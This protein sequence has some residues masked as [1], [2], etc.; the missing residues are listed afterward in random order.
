[1]HLPKPHRLLCLTATAALA[2]AALCGCSQSDD[3]SPAGRPAGDGHI[4]FGAYVSTASATRANIANIGSLRKTGFGVFAATTGDADYDASA[5]A[6]FTCDFMHNQRVFWKADAS[7]APGVGTWSYEPAKSWPA[8]KVT[9]MA[10]APYT[11][12]F[13]ET[14]V[15]AVTAADSKGSPR[16]SFRMASKVSEQTDLIYSDTQ[17]TSNLRNGGQ[18]EFNFRHAMSRLGLKLGASATINKG[19]Y[20]TVTGV[21]LTFPDTDVAGTFDLAAGKWEE[22]T[23][24]TLECTL[25]EE[26]FPYRSNIINQSNGTTAKEITGDGTYLMLIPTERPVKVTVTLYY[27]VA[28]IDSNLQAG[29]FAVSNEVSDSFEFTFEAG[30][31]YYFTLRV[32]SNGLDISAEAADWDTTIEQGWESE[33][34]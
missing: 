16:L 28:T 26:D 25:S 14:G 1:M 31:S 11:A 17:K 6:G 34:H 12:T 33:T 24:S 18:V 5:A 3:P 10:Y 13:G 20:F 15:T 22:K 23:R 7:G 32:G 2:A 27:D 21:K 9:F 29:E 4:E 19:S 8:S 30:K